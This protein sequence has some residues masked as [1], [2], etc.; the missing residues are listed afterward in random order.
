MTE[1]QAERMLA[2][3]SLIYAEI[4]GMR[5]DFN[6]FRAYGTQNMEAVTGSLGYSITDLA[7]KLDDIDGKLAMIDINTAP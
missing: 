2:Y 5:S 6:E 7:Q 3:R 1:D 4:E